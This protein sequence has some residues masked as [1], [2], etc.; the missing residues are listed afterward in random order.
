MDFV[1]DCS[2]KKIPKNVKKELQCKQKVLFRGSYDIINIRNI[3]GSYTSVI[4]TNI[5]ENKDGINIVSSIFEY[6]NILEPTTINFL[7]E[8]YT[9]KSY[10]SSLKKN[11]GTIVF[12]SFYP[13]SGSDGI[14]ATGVYS[15]LVLNGDGIYEGIKSVI[16]DFSESIRQLYFCA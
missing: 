7:Q 15:F 10:D 1:K 12:T 13:D 3:V 5:C 16:I 4:K 8:T 11:K 2:I 9:L 6:I 14:T